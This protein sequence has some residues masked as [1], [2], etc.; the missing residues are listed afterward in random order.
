MKKALHLLDGD[1]HDAALAA[2]VHPQEWKNPTP[3]GRYN[4]VVLGAGTAGLVAAAGAAGLGARVAIIER[5]LMGGDCL[6]YGCVP[7]KALIRSAR[8]AATVRESRAYGV[9]A[10]EPKVDFE[11]VMER[12]RSLRAG[13]AQHDSAERFKGLGVDVHLGEGRFVAPDAVEVAGQRLTFSRAIIATGGKPAVPSI[14]GLEEAGYLTNETVFTLTS[15]PARLVVLGAGPIGCELAQALRRLGARVA[16]IGKEER[17]LPRE[18]PEAGAVLTQRFESEGITLHL[19]AQV[20]RVETH[21]EVKRVHFERGGAVG[22]V[23][24]EALLISTGRSPELESLNL[25][26]AG[27][28]AGPHGVEVDDRLCTSNPRVYAAGDICSRF[29][30]T[31][32]ADALARVALQ[33]ALFLGRKKA[34]ALVIPWCTYTDPEVAHVGLSAQEAAARGD[35]VVTLTVPMSSVDRAILE[36]ETEGF[37][38]IHVEAK[39]GKLLGGTIVGSHAGENIGELT[40]AMT[41]GLTVGSLSSTVLPY[42][43]QGEVLKKLGDAWNRRRLTPRAKNFLTRFLTWRR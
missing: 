21:G 20:T 26:A 25:E 43:T 8:V 41:Q 22:V 30:F 9:E 23:E 4:L 39:S 31:H 2:R 38:R 28:R 5:R 11:K 1:A 33:N 15:L 6:N 29:K 18:D 35:E 19:G 24:G 7:S 12:V 13:I 37:G 34:S 32:A 14:P 10:G 27:V 36:S 42:P 17:L 16:L 3:E 40:L